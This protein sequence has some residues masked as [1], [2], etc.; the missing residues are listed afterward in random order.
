MRLQPLLVFCW[1]DCRFLVGIEASSLQLSRWEMLC[2]IP[3]HGRGCLGLQSLVESHRDARGCRA[4]VQQ[5]TWFIRRR[6]QH[7][8][9][10][11]IS[12]NQSVRADSSSISWVYLTPVSIFQFEV[13][14]FFPPARCWEVREHSRVVMLWLWHAAPGVLPA[15]S[16]SPRASARTSW[17]NQLFLE[18]SPR[19]MWWNSVPSP[20]GV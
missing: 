12:L 10:R 8:L 18:M 15:T 6:W 1:C 14:S 16:A 19:L 11:V 5:E 7:A 20:S 9:H 2:L 17:A 4:A 3:Q 13:Y